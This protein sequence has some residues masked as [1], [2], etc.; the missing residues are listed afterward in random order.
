[1]P[2]S[3][4]YCC[5]PLNPRR[6]DGHFSAEAQAVRARDGVV[7]L[8]D[9]DALLRG[10]V[11]RAVERVPVELGAVWYRGW[12]IPSERYRALARVLDQRGVEL[13][14]SPE[15]YRAAHELPGWYPT[16]A[17]ETPASVWSAGGVGQIP[18]AEAL[19]SLAAGLRPGP[20]IVKD[21]VKSRKHEWEEAC[22]IRDLSD[23]AAV[24]RV[25]GRFVELQGEFLTGGIVLREFESFRTPQSVAAEVRVWW[26]DGQARLLTP[27]PDSPHVRGL[28]PELGCVESAVQRL[29]CRFVT[30]DMALRAD[31]VWRVVEVGDGQVSD[32]HVSIDP[33]DLV[34]LLLAG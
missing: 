6:V 5:D 32:L 4:L 26:L 19:A 24:A 25:V 30:T 18:A 7:A 33:A 3:L 34:R 20:G 12:M 2:P 13:L 11:E 29:G 17:D 10:E 31:G 9:H 16:F 8:I 28:E 14:V 23:T 27:H 22:F 15:R 1:M 21:Y